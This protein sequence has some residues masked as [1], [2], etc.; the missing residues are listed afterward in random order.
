MYE[1]RIVVA[2]SLGGFLCRE[3]TFFRSDMAQGLGDF[4]RQG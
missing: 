4:P 1:V 2:I 3:W